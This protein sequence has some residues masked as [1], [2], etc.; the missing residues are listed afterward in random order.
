[1][2]SLSKN[3]L[4]LQNIQ[5]NV[6]AWFAKSLHIKHNLVYAVEFKT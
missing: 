2:E 5:E 4:R 6:E 1:M 3:V